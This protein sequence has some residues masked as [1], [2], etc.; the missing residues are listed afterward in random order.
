MFTD[1]LVQTMV[2]PLT[3]ILDLPNSINRRSILRRRSPPSLKLR[4]TLKELSFGDAK[5]RLF[6]KKAI[7]FQNWKTSPNIRWKQVSGLKFKVQG[8]KF[9]VPGSG[10]YVLWW[11]LIVFL[12]Y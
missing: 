8:S 9:K 12:G 7:L 6:F 11:R 10:F 1:L 2:L 5:V 4:W 3:G